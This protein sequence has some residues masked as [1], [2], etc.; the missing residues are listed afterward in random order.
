MATR[1]ES[2]VQLPVWYLVAIVVLLLGA[3]IM[4]PIVA[5]Q[6]ADASGATPT[7]SPTVTSSP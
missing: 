1:S 5:D 7:P 2:V 3:L 6:R 4:A